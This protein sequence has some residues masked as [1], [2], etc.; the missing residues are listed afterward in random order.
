MRSSNSQP[1][2]SNLNLYVEN[3][4][5]RFQSEI[6]AAIFIDPALI[7]TFSQGEKGS[8]LPQGED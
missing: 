3:F 7:L 5:V 1:L 8:P 6:A 2:Q 4:F